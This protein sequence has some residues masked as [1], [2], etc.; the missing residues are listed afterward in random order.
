MSI[1]VIVFFFCLGY[2]FRLSI[3]P[4]WPFIRIV[5]LSYANIRSCF[6]RHP[7]YNRKFAWR[8]FWWITWSEW[9]NTCVPD[10]LETWLLTSTE[11]GSKISQYFTFSRGK[12]TIA[13]SNS[14]YLMF[15]IL[16]F[17]VDPIHVLIYLGLRKH[18]NYVFKTSATLVIPSFEFSRFL[19]IHPLPFSQTVARVA[20][21]SLSLIQSPHLYSN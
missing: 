18:S 5:S 4:F 16:T 14:D 9:R 21:Q 2:I 19:H 10:E 20:F 13:N 11:H 6:R 3:P 7:E 17:F 1:S 12:D 8:T 15:M